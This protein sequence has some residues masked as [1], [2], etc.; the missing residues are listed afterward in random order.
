MEPTGLMEPSLPMKF[1]RQITLGRTGLKVGRLGI[2]SSFGAPA[3]AIEEAFERGCNYFT[4]GTFIRGRSSGMKTAIKNIVHR[5]Q[6]R[7]PVLAMVSYAHSAILT[8][9]YFEKCVKTWRFLKM[10]LSLKRN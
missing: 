9:F 1:D 10:V 5:G 8:D 7:N 6:C 3:A 2:S 4:W